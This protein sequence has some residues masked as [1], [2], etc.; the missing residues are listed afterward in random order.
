MKSAEIRTTAHKANGAGE[1]LLKVNRGSGFLV[2]APL[3]VSRRS[4]GARALQFCGV[5]ART[6]KI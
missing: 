2:F 6:E 5:G 4:P 3:E 1:N